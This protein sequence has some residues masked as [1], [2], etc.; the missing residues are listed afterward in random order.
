MANYKITQLPSASIATGSNVLPIVQGGDTDQIT[1]TNL[2]QGILNLGLS[3]TGSTVTANS[4]GAG[5]NFRVGD[6]VWIGD[7]NLANTMQVA[8]IQ[9]ATK[10]FIKFSSGSA[11]PIIGST[12]NNIFQITGSTQIT[13]SGFINGN[14]ILTSADTG[15]F[16]TTSSLPLNYGLFNQTGSSTPISASTSE[17]SLIGGGVGNLTVPANTFKKGDAYHV[18]LTGHGTFSNNNTLQIKIKA[19]TVILADTGLLTLS[20]TNNKHWKLEIFFT[21]NNIGSTGIA[22]IS[23]GGNFAYTSDSSDKYNGINF[24]TENNTTFDTTISNILNITGQF[25][26][27]N[28]IIY[29]NICTLVK[30]F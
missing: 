7:V 24:S 28:N 10:G 13:G 19:G 26:T 23:T 8:G 25:N 3:I 27:L 18:I 21:I 29:S 5:T 1:V 22:S 17:L 14:A 2:G 6:D 11:S 20:G 30:T 16:V 4:N 9:D 15:S 12:G